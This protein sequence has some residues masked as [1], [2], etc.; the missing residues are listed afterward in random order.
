VTVAS[1][2]CTEPA[3]R[4]LS[5]HPYRSMGIRDVMAIRLHARTVLPLLAEELPEPPIEEDEAPYPGKCV[6][7]GFQVHA[8]PRIYGT[9]TA[10]MISLLPQCPK[11]KGVDGYQEG[12][13]FAE[14]LTTC[15]S[16]PDRGSE[17]HGK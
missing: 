9:L 4:G 14:S 13:R 3:G 5:S 2:R 12:S 10:T 11:V 1:K 7:R 8:I 15:G 17:G 16:A 6:Q